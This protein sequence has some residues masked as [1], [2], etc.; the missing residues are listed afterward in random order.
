MARI[1][2]PAGD[3]GP[4]VNSHERRVALFRFKVN[5]AIPFHG[6]GCAITEHVLI[7]TQHPI[8]EGIS[9]ERL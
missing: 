6:D 7:S 3:F 8:F 5:E 4:L 1:A 2:T 9:L